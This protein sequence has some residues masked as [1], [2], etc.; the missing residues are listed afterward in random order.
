MQRFPNLLAVSLA[1][2]LLPTGQATA[3]GFGNTLGATTLGHPLN[4]AV[5]LRLEPDERI[6]ASCVKADV[7]IGDH[8]L[9]SLSVRVRIEGQP[10]SNE[11]RLRITT[12]VPVEEPVVG[13]ALN[14]G[15]PTRLSRN[16]VVFADPPSAT[17]VTPANAL[18]DISDQPDTSASPLASVIAPQG[19]PAVR[20]T[21]PRVAS[22]AP[23]A[24]RPR[25]AAG[26]PT[27]ATGGRPAA[28]VATG[29]AARPQK[30]AAEPARPKGPTLQL[31]PVETD[32]LISPSLRMSGQLTQLAEAGQAGSAP[33]RFIDPELVQRLEAQDRLKALESSMNQLRAEGQARQQALVELQARVQQAQ[34]ARYA[35]PLVYALAV[36]CALL[37][38]GLGFLVWQRWRER[39]AAAWWVEP[40]APAPVAAAA[41]AEAPQTIP[42]AMS[43]DPSGGG[44]VLVD[45]PPPVRKR[46]GSPM[47][48]QPMD[49]TLT[50]R[51]V[52]AMQATLSRE[53]RSDLDPESLEPHRPMSAD[54]LID[55]DQQVEFFVVL[56]QDDAA[57]D[58]LM[59]HVRSTGGVSPLPY[60]K[61]MEIYRRRGE[62]DPY[63]RIRE[64]FNRRFNAYAIEWDEH[65]PSKER[66][67]EE[68]FP[69]LLAR[70][71]S[72]WSAPAEAMATL[73]GALFRRNQGPPFDV[74]AYRDLLFL[75][76]IARDLAERDV[77]P[78]G[79]DLLL[80]MEGGFDITLDLSAA[81]VRPDS[82]PMPPHSDPAPPPPEV[83]RLT[84]DLDI[85]TDPARLSGPGAPLRDASDSRPGLD[86]DL[87]ELSEL[88]TTR[89]P[90]A[91]GSR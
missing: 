7:S 57:V 29:K 17:V 56:G 91:R 50:P 85:S 45:T 53:V 5:M 16:Y 42:A 89:N 23:A 38:A 76:G 59:G 27:A 62:R 61:L 88:D 36:L 39:Q 13:I 66:D 4:F 83:E 41:P 58:L 33:Y 65:D 46:P 26:Q 31:D 19:E 25:A 64:R 28:K 32:A 80:P 22:G 81:E 55:L 54:E 47:P 90:K 40:P 82:A 71:Q 3:M 6:E 74:P 10:G 86:F 24:Q 43:P 11:R 52:A 75:Y 60:L 9:S 34:A 21:L 44:A 18:P 67:L 8:A 84:L 49:V 78:E 1:L 79:V 48:T 77:R 30:P 2:G 63:D 14:V 73:D 69:E 15:C 68:G 87:S 51:A 35:N 72:L 12:T 20:P 70:V 37:A